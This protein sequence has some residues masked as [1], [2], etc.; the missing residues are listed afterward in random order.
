[1]PHIQGAFREILV[2]DAS[3]AVI[4][5]DGLPV[6]RAAFG[7][8][9][10]VCLHGIGQAGSLVGKRVLVTGCGPIGALAIL[11]ARHAGAREIVATD[12]QDAPLAV[13]RRIGADRT[14]NVRSDAA[15][16][17][18][19]GAD[20]GTFDVVLEASG[21]GA[22]MAAALQAARP[23]ATIVQFG[24]GGEIPLPVNALVAKEISLRGSF[25]FHAEFAWAIELIAS[26]AID[27]MP[28]LTEIV[29]LAEAP[30]AFELAA[31]RSRAMKVLLAL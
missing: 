5:P 3:Q 1:M 12:L 9:L 25:R 30:R 29:P 4:L 24:L 31:D 18:A 8:P 13:A 10:S 2:C 6:E 27:V 16:L 14:I 11:A 17:E 7:E 20:K 26:G 28:L 15:A 22:A 23:R 19:Y 21:S